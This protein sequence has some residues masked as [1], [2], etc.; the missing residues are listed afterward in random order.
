MEIIVDGF[1]V[2]YIVRRTTKRKIYI[3]VK[4]DIV[5]IS[6]TK[7]TTIK[8]IEKLI[9]KHIEFIKN[10]L[11]N[12]KKTDEIHLNGVSYKPVFNI[13]YKN[14]VV[15]EKD[16]III[17]CKKDDLKSKQKVLHDF[18]KAEVLKVLD[19]IILEAKLD[20]SE[21]TFPTISVCYLKSMFGNY[22]RKKHHIKISSILAKY[23]YSFI[24]LVLYHELSHVF[25]FNHSKKYYEIFNSK[26]PNA[27]KL[28]FML[29]KIKYHDC[30]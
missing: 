9:I 21:I 17:T 7:K 10:E 16:N 14:S 15:V 2:N 28:N 25:E 27:K 8:E 11:E 24:K 1:K 13:G 6:V 4:D 12:K 18:Y 5:Y 26:Y 3:R 20:F 29:K 22:N 23:D 19:E 30:I